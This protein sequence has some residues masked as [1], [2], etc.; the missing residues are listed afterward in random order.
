MILR[1]NAMRTQTAK[2]ML[3]DILFCTHARA[4]VTKTAFYYIKSKFLLHNSPRKKD[5]ARTYH[6]KH[7][8]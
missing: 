8:A 6:A 7:A 5:E 3:G 2:S 1:K 4:H